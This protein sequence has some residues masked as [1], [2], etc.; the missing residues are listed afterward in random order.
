M[1]TFI[2]LVLETLYKCSLTYNYIIRFIKV[3]IKW[4]LMYEIVYTTETLL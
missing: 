4:L 3:Y 1:Y 2:K